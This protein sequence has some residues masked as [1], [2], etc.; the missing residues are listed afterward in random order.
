MK[1]ASVGK[2]E[3]TDFTEISEVLKSVAHPS[4][5]A[6]ISLLCNCGCER[7]TVKNIYEQLKFEQ[8]VTSKHLGIMKKSGLLKRETEGNKIYFLLNKENAITSCLTDCLIIK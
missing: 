5:I 3:I 8:A 4:R 6:I 1:N 7:L 2:K